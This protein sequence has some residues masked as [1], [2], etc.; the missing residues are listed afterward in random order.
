MTMLVHIAAYCLAI[1]VYLYITLAINPRY[2]LHRMP[3]S[4]TEKVAPRTKA[5]TRQ[6]TLLGLPFLAYMI[7]HPLWWAAAR[8]EGFI[9]PILSLFAFFAAFTVWDTLVLDILFFCTLT[10]RFLV[11]EGTTKADYVDKLY[12]AR[13][14]LKGLAISAIGSA[15]IGSLIFAIKLAIAALAR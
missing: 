9:A 13:A 4:V 7:G 14:G 12:H 11:M 2:W 6:I 15:V 8:T 5:E 3:A 10:P 1:S